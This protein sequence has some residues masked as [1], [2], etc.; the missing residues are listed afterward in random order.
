MSAC[1]S[2]CVLCRLRICRSV[3][4]HAWCVDAVST[5]ASACSGFEVARVWLTPDSVVAASR[6]KK[7]YLAESL[8]KLTSGLPINLDN[9]QDMLMGRPFIPG[10][11][12]VTLADS[13][14]MRLDNSSGS[15]RL[16]P[17]RQHPMAD[18]GYVLD[19][20]SV[21]TALA[22]VAADHDV[23]FTASYSGPS[24]LPLREM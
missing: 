11:S 12:T 16:L 14:A 5:L 23:S 19:L 10:G 8:S 13:A 20:P 7:V 1:R 18:Y 15:L 21:V 22:V 3:R 24:R 6:P 17:R 9:L 2:P 4:V